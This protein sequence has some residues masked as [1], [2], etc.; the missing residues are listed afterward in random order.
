MVETDEEAGMVTGKGSYDTTLTEAEIEK[1]LREGI[2]DSLVRGKRVL[3]LTPDGTR[4]APLP[5]MTRRILLHAGKKATRLDFMAALGTH[6]TLSEKELDS[7]YGIGAKERA[8]SSFFNHRWDRPDTFRKIGTIAEREVARISGGLLSEKM[9]IIIN[10][11]VYDYDLVIVLGPVFPHEL[12]GFS[13]GNKYFFPGVSGGEFM[14]AFHWLGALIG[15]MEIIGKKHTPTRALIDRAASLITPRKVCVSMVVDV[16]KIL[17]GLFVGSMEESWEKAADLSEQVHVKRKKRPYRLVIGVAPAM[18]DELWTAGKVMYKLEPVVKDGGEL[19]IYAPH[20]DTV[21][22]TWGDWL[23]RIGYHVRD[24]YLA[25]A[26]KF[27]DVPKAVLAH[28]TLV[29]GAGTCV[30]GSERPRIRVTLASGISEEKCERLDLGYR[31]PGKIDIARYKNKED[32]GV[33]VVEN[34]GETLYRLD[35]GA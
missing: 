28:S 13:G 16:Q 7:L 32:E 30:N 3:V 31:D 33:L 14:H 5:L 35:T 18:Y 15:C 2:D 17:R 9:D 19:V 10:R 24:Y 20:I 8:G 29:K 27:D 1:I 23:S 11:I 21:S 22:H 4:T 12:V 25:V 6:R 26:G 34:A